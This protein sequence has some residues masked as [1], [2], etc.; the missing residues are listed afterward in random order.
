MVLVTPELSDTDLMRVGVQFLHKVWTSYLNWQA[1]L[2][3]PVKNKQ[4]QD[5]KMN[6]FLHTAAEIQ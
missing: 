4:K 3:Y 1:A 6:L 2:Y 5:Q